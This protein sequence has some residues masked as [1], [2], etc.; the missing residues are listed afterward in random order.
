[1]LVV[2][3]SVRAEAAGDV[4]LV[5]LAAA[6]GVVLMAWPMAPI[7]A[8][9]VW[10]TSNTIAHNFIHRP[11]IRGRAANQAFALYLSVLLGIPQALWRERHLAHHAGREPSLRWTPELAVQVAA[12]LALWIAVA[13]AAPVF[14]ALT[15]LPGYLGGLA[16]CALH[17]YYEHEH[18]T[19]SHYGRLYN[20]LFFNDGYHVEHHARPGVHW[21]RL[22][23]YRDADA[24]RSLWPAPLRFLD[25]CGLEALERVVLRSPLLQ[26]FVIGTHERALRSL[27]APARSSIGSIAIVGGGLFPR[28]AIVLRRLCPE[29]RITVIDANRDNLDCARERLDGGAIE[30]RHARYSPGRAEGYDLIVIP[31]SFAGDRAA[32]YAQPPAPLVIVH[33]WIWRARGDSRIVALALMKRI[34]L[35]RR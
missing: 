5:A 35:I 12:V 31:L 30:F 4:L 20:L 21:S 23:A 22:P 2:R 9:G 14:F 25:A 7:I 19:T 10:W 16:L 29:A 18:G 15:Y 6:H 27:L 11:F 13:L 33:D 8:V 17:G 28:T 24:R 32:V 1:V 26:R 3:R 34:N